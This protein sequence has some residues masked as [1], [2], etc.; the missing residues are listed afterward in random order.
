MLIFW[1]KLLKQKRFSSN[2]NEKDETAAFLEGGS[3]FMTATNFTALKD[4]VTETKLQID[5]I[6]TTSFLH[7]SVRGVCNSNASVS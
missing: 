2:K 4:G 7:P 3:F 5:N 1:Q 6:S